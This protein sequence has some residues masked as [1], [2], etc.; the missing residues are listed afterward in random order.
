M[1][2][3]NNLGDQLIKGVKDKRR[4]LSRAVEATAK[5]SEAGIKKAITTGVKPPAVDTG[6]MRASVQILQMRKGLVPWAEVGPTVDYAVYVHEGLG[7]NRR[8]GARPFIPIGLE[9]QSKAFDRIAEQT[10]RRLI[11]SLAKSI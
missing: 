7:T 8:I 11:T 1:S 6:N 2:Q 5:V 4:N 3:L 9:M 10:G